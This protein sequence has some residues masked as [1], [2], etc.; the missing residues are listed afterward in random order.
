MHVADEK[1]MRTSIHHAS[2]NGAVEAVHALLKHGASVHAPDKWG[3]SPLHR[4]ARASQQDSSARMVEYLLMSGADER[5]VDRDGHTAADVVH[6]DVLE[7]LVMLDSLTHAANNPSVRERLA[8]AAAERADRVWRRRSLVVMCR[9]RLIGA[10]PNFPEQD[11]ASRPAKFTRVRGGGGADDAAGNVDTRG[12]AHRGTA[13]GASV[14]DD[15]NDAKCVVARVVGL[16]EDGVFRNL[17]KF[18]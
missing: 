5:A 9:A 7:G 10:R 14:P 15:D 11:A 2:A 1:D 12:I 6:Q 16:Q 13:E 4:A 17:M 18:L 3:D 8:N